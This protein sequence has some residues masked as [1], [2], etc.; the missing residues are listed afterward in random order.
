MTLC[1]F[2]ELEGFFILKNHVI[3]NYNIRSYSCLLILNYN[4][5]FKAPCVRPILLVSKFTWRV[6]LQRI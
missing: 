2:R 4:C 3:K 1:H 5:S 6:L